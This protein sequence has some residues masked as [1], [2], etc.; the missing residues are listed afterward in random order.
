[1]LCEGSELMS[2][3]SPAN[4]QHWAGSHH[5]VCFDKYLWDKYGMRYGEE[6]MESVEG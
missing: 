2:F 4:S 5:V 3:W 6:I 1:M